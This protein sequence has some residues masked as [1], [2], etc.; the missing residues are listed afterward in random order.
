[1]SK[2]IKWSR[3]K[4]GFVKSKCGRFSISP[5]YCGST[6]PEFYEMRDNDLGIKYG[7]WATTQR[8]LKDRAQETIDEECSINPA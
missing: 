1:M 4:E 8:E 3:S 2:N 6:R 5:L 7:G